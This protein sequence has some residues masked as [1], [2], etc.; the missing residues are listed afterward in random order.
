VTETRGSSAG[1]SE[2]PDDGGEWAPE[3]PPGRIVSLPGRGRVFVRDVV[4]PPG[5]PVLFLLHGWTATADLNWF[6]AYEPLGEHYRVVAFDHRGHGRGLRTRRRF[7]LADCADDVVAMAD[8]LGIDRFVPVGYSMGGPIATLVWRR[9]PGRVRGLVLCATASRFG[10]S[11]LVRAQLAMFGPVALSSRV[12]PYRFAKPLFDRLIWSRTRDS[13]L[14]PWV[15]REILSGEPRHVLEAGA[16]LHNFDNRS[17][18]E[19]IDV[20][21]AMIVV[22][23]DD[24]VPTAHQDQLASAIP[25]ARVLRIEG[26]HDVCVR[27]PRRFTR[28]IIEACGAVV[29]A[30]ADPAVAP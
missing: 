6:P 18:V 21:T 22:D 4:G 12:L 17:W 30:G 28:A 11:R 29:A 13:G 24:I 14:Q 20:P 26:G 19:H 10:T 27:H 3:L 23:G 25:N 15:V 8:A 9:N 1:M 2:E 7:R 16:A 5:A